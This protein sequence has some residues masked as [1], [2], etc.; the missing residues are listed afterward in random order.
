MD[1]TSSEAGQPAIGTV[2]VTGASRGIGLDFVRAWLERGAHVIAGCRNPTS[3]SALGTL[4]SEYGERLRV[5]QLDVVDERSVE[6]MAGAIG[7][8]PIDLLINNAGILQVETLENMDFASI[9]DQFKVNALGALH[10][11]RSLLSNL[12]DGAKIINI[13]SRMGSL[14]DNTSGGYYGYRMSKA[15]LNM[16][17]RSLAVD[18]KNRGIIVVAMHPGMVQTDLTRGFGMLTAAESVAGMNQVIDKLTIEQSGLF[19]HY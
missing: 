15:A 19:L 2:L 7:N 12:R 1:E 13:T 17:T 4:M 5:M 11:T 8:Q 6:T 16:A 3:A 18:L 14:D 9:L 10:V